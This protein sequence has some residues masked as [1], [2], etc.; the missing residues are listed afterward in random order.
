V[1]L[2]TTVIAE[3]TSTIGTYGRAI[4]AT[5][6]LRNNL[7]LSVGAYSSQS[8]ALNFNEQNA[9]VEHCDRTFGKC[10]SGGELF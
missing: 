10:Q 3:V 8:T 6:D 4:W 1:P 5:A 7:D 2:K 9:T